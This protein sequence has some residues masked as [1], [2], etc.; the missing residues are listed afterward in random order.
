MSRIIKGPFTLK[1]GDN[2]IEDVEEVEVEH[3]VS[4][5]DYETVQ[6]KTLEVDGPYKVGVTLTLLATDIPS[7]A[8][9]MPQYFVPNGGQLSTGETV[10]EANGAMDIK[11]A[12]CDEDTVYDNLDIIACGGGNRDVMRI[13]HART[14]MEGVELDGSKI[15]KVQVRFIGESASDE[16]T[17]QFFKENSIAVVS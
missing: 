7:L 8:A 4:S 5:D 1:F 17:M 15:R 14:R 9:V 11:A 16:A 3:E 13:V 10:N 2:L 12:S 6:G